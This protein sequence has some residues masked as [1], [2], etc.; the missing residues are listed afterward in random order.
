MTNLFPCWENVLIDDEAV[1]TVPCLKCNA[2][3]KI[4]EE[5]ML[6]HQRLHIE[7][8]EQERDKYVMN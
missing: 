2:E 1:P 5:S 3:I 4:D 7:E 6:N 8:E